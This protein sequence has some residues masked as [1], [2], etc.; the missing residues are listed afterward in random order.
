MEVYICDDASTDG[1]RAFLVDRPTWYTD[2]CTHTERAGWPQ[3]LND[4]AQIAIKDG[5][6]LLFTMN[7]D[8][9]LRLDCIE[10]SVEAIKDH[11]WVVVYA[12]Q[13]GAANVIQASKEGATLEDFKI[14]PPLVNYALIPSALWQR[15]DGYP[16]D[17]SL[18]NSYG[19]KEDWGFWIKVF[20]SGHTNYAVVKEPVYYYLMHPGQ[21]HESGLDRH[22]EAKR[23]ILERYGL[24]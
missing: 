5:C 2:I 20:Q 23:I 4:A 3:S 15:V 11:D 13:V 14:Y 24:R 7:A 21:L 1:T 18:P 10:K 6:D 12:Q 16:T 9:F 22:E 19:Y 8:D 17:I